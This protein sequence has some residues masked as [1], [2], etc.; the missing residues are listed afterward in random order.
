[1]F[2]NNLRILI[3][4][5]C[6]FGILGILVITYFYDSAAVTPEELSNILPNDQ[7]YLVNGHIKNIIEKSNTL[8]FELCDYFVCIDSVYFNPHESIIT[9]LKDGQKITIKAKY[10]NYNDSSE[11]I[12]FS[13][14]ER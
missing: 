13:F 11:L 6:I 1:M 3:I 7:I 10:S 4:S 2:E 14:V 5:A 9:E 12:V 8:F